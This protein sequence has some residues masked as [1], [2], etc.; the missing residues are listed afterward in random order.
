VNNN[1]VKQAHLLIFGQVQGVGFRFRTKKM[2]DNLGLAGWVRNLPDGR[3]EAV[4]QGSD[5]LVD[6][7]VE[8]C[9]QGSSSAQ[10]NQVEVVEQPQEDLTDFEIKR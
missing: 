10:V 8:W 6:R 4:F 5:D 2:A 9:H 3:V 7:A 1:F